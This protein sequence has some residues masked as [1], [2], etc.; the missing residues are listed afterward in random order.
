MGENVGGNVGGEIW[1]EY[2]G[3]FRGKSKFI[4]MRYINK[5]SVN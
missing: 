5:F 1:G 2:M 3:V 4:Y